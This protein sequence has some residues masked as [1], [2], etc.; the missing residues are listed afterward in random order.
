MHDL[1]LLCDAGPAGVKYHYLTPTGGQSYV[2]NFLITKTNYYKN[3]INVCATVIMR[4]H[5]VD[6]QV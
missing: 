6:I 1:S 4:A 3:K 5:L 2:I